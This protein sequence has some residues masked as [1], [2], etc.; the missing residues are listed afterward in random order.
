M[1]TGMMRKLLL[2]LL[3][4]VGFILAIAVVVWQSRAPDSRSVASTAP[5]PP[6]AS[7]VAGSGI[8]E[9]EQG[10]IEI[11][12]PVPGIL[13][14][15]MVKVGDQVKT[16]DPLFRIDD[17]DLQAQLSTA[18]A[19]LRVA[20]AEVDQPK[21]RLEYNEMLHKRDSGAVSGQQLT[22]LRDQLSVA[23]ANRQLAQAQVTQ[24]R[25]EI[26][27]HLVRAPVDGQVL[28]MTLRPGEYL[29]VAG[30]TPLLL[31]GE[32][33]TLYLRVD[34]DETDAWRIRPGAPAMAFARGNPHIRI[35]LKFEYIEP[36]ISAKRSLTGRSTERT[37]T[38]VLQ[39]IY[40]F[41]RAGAPVYAGEQM[42]VFIQTEP[43]PYGHGVG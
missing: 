16:G 1:K 42:D 15:V 39:V 8:I 21:H 6:Y 13:S 28:R 40:S 32:E 26:D 10:N 3:A 33:K 2:P 38:R 43:D 12:S 27:R 34:V 35:P 23:E 4:S 30:S 17:R 29:S 22:E 31:F 20:M 25:S 24:I 7:F 14:E 5:S 37:D 9:T 19:K 11:G 18:E 41:A 36:Y